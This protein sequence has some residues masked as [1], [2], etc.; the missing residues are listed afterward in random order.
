MIKKCK[1]CQQETEKFYDKRVKS[2]FF[3]CKACHYFF[4]DE[5]S[6]LSSEAELALYN[7]HNNSLENKGY[8]QMLEEYIEFA[9]KPFDVHTILEFGSG[10]TPVLSELLQQKSY[11]VDMYDKFYAPTKVYEGKVYDLI[12]ST[13]VI[14][15]I[16][17][18]NELMQFF[19]KHLK[20]GG[21][22]ALMTQFHKDSIEEFVKWWYPCDRTHISFFNLHTFEV[23]AEK[24]HFRIVKCDNKK[25]IVLQKI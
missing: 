18:I 19:Y 24:F 7:Q 15:H 12:S 20:K 1:I 2:D 9:I 16:E 23:L 3:Y 10:P 13:E 11:S 17:G 21:Y 4:K 25:M 6:F 22:L 8:V 5:A 14:E